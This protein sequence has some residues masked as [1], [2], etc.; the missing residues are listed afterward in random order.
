MAFFSVIIPLYNKEKYVD[1]TIQSIINQTF[2]DYEV[3]I[4]ND[5]STDESVK[6]VM[7]FLSNAVQLIE[8]KN[9][10]G[11]S[12]ARNTGIKNAKAKYITFLDADDQ[13][14]PNFLETLFL[15]INQ[16]PEAGIFATNYEEIYASKIVIPDNNTQHLKKNSSQIIDFFKYNLG[17]GIYNHGSVCFDKKV[18]ETVGN[19]DENI[20]FAEDIDF[21]IRA[22]LNFQLAFSNTVGMSYQMQTENQL[23]STSIL[24]KRVPNYDNYEHL[25]D[26][27]LC[28]KK[29]LDFERYVLAKHVK[30]DGDYN[31]YLKI[32]ASIDYKNLNQ[33][34]KF[35]LNLPGFI[36]KLINKIKEFLQLKG[37][38]ITSYN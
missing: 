27:N 5:A 9:N 20:D 33:K 26:K 11:L 19:Y 30:T 8:H 22:N 32:I 17:Q 29:Y 2:T 21:N 36:L 25:A 23:T 38:K 7:P 12:A 34:Q 3:L 15:L 6:K 31:L 10:K 24:N 13:W 1:N 14:K 37:I 28:L 35:L 18:F 16:F 4:I